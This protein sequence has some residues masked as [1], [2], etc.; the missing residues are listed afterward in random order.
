MHEM[1]ISGTTDGLD[2]A[3]TL[4]RTGQRWQ[5][6][7]L[8]LQKADYGWALIDG[9]TSETRFVREPVNELEAPFGVYTPCPTCKGGGVAT[10]D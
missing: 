9:E 7:K 8:V 2:G 4:Q 10:V 5:S 6:G 1:V 3:S